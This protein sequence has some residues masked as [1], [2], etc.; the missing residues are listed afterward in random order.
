MKRMFFLICFCISAYS[1][2]AQSP[3][4]ALQIEMKD[5][6]GSAQPSLIRVS[7]GRDK[8]IIKQ[9]SEKKFEISLDPI[10]DYPNFI[11]IE[12]YRDCT[13][14]IR[15]QI[16]AGFTVR[17]KAFASFLVTDATNA[18]VV[19]NDS[20]SL[21]H[22]NILQK[23]YREMFERIMVRVNQFNENTGK[24]LRQAYLAAQNEAEKDSIERLND[25]MFRINAGRPNLDSVL[26]PCIK[27]NLNNVISLHAM[28][29]YI[30]Q[31]RFFRFDVPGPTFQSYLQ[32]MPQ[33]LQQ[34]KLW[35]ELDEITK[36]I[37]PGSSLIGKK[38][39]EFIN[40]KDSSG[41]IV[42]LE[43]FKGKIVFIDF[44]AS[45]CAPCMAQVPQLK[46]AYQ[47]V[48]G[49]NVEFVAISLDES[50]HNWKQ[51]I[52]K[53]Q[54]SWINLTDLKG[55]NS[56][57]AIEYKALLIPHN[58]LIDKNGIVVKENIPVESLEKTIE[59]LL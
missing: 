26:M 24:K 57:T 54:L 16:E 32:S 11:Q 34:L 7:C 58:L 46:K 47:Q 23:K 45:W 35:K 51:A 4:Y 55:N 3:F 19:M 21:L 50:L 29:T 28:N 41:R 15:K 27:N 13:N 10:I 39:P 40:L 9:V 14:E 48:Q 52:R 38:A 36:V 12:Y 22:E 18:V 20:I 53:S 56:L 44:W 31:S 49:K 37:N 5:F 59:E 33:N 8:F 2:L 17:T 30:S 1:L 6:S 43:Q 25:N 42:Q